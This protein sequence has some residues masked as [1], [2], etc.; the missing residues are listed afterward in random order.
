MKTIDCSLKGASC[1]VFRH[2]IGAKFISY[3]SDMETPERAYSVVILRI[4]KID[5][6]L[7]IDEIKSQEAWI[8]DTTTTTAK[9]VRLDE[10]QSP[11]GRRD[12]DGN[13]LP[14]KF[15][16]YPADGVVRHISLINE[17]TTLND[18][19]IPSCELITTRGYIVETDKGFV[20]FDKTESF[21]EVWTITSG[22][23]ETYIP[24]C[25]DVDEEAPEF[26]TRVE[27]I[28]VA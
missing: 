25:V 23:T 4:G 10:V 6:E 9:E 1:D 27:V 2:L 14:N 11:A 26:K 17:I 7:R 20:A 5:L 13:Y 19:D 3:H 12:E 28:Q 22:T 24:D 8:A 21:G 18:G 16:S 15:L